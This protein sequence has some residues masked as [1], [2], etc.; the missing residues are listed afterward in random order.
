ML[1]GLGAGGEL[2]DDELA[3][4]QNRVDEAFPEDLTNVTVSRKVDLG[5]GL[6]QELRVYWSD[7]AHYLFIYALYHVRADDMIILQFEF[8]ND[9]ETVMAAF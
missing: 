9:P 8:D 5:G 6:H 1:A 7:D 3:A 4:L 2:S